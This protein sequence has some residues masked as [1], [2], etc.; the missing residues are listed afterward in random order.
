VA[1]L[2]V[3]TPPLFSPL[4]GTLTRSSQ[5]VRVGPNE[6]DIPN[7]DELSPTYRAVFL[8]LST[9]TKNAAPCL[10]RERGTSRPVD[11]AGTEATER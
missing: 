1:R 10:R 8:F 4:A 11:V 6:V 3:R 2:V 5:T 9:V 7:C